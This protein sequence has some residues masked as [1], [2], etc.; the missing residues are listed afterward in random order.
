MRVLCLAATLLLVIGC[1]E[2][3]V[4]APDAVVVTQPGIEDKPLPDAKQVLADAL[5]QAGRQN[6]LLFVH[7]ASPG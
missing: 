4:A 1:Q 7:F 6:K 3:D 5:A 2:S